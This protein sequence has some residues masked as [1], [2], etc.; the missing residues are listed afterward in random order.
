VS[1]SE[2]TSRRVAVLVVGAGPVGLSAALAVRA[3]GLPVAVL[4][5]E[6]EDQPKPGSR[7]IFVHRESLRHLER[8]SP[9]LGWGLAERGLVWST[10]RTFWGRRQVY[11]HTY[12]PPA[13]DVLPHSTNLPQTDT[14]RLLLDACRSAGIEVAWDSRVAAVRSQPDGV[15]V[16]TEA[17]RRWGAD[18]VV[19]ADGAQSTVR[20]LLAIP[21]EGSRS[22]NVFVIVDVAEDEEAPR[23]PERIFHY[24]HPEVGRRNVLLVPFAGGWRADL[25]CRA[26]DD[27]ERWSDPAGV[28]RWIGAVLSPGYAERV[29]WVS[30]YRFLQVVAERFADDTGR[31]LLTGEAAHLFAPFGAR[32]MNSGIA[33]A[34]A[35]AVAIGKA[36][37]AGDDPRARRAAVEDFAAR[38]R[39]AALY[40]RQA[41][42][43]ALAHLQGGGVATR[44]GGLAAAALA[45]VGQRAGGWLDA[46]PYG[47]RAGARGAPPGTY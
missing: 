18:Y 21:L 34:A 45:W 25:Q 11:E 13:A 35:A 29:T 19:A 31:V 39:Q 36:I 28:R 17:G 9:G 5:A 30:S 6:P 37:D 20:R 44:V 23:R 10:K 24:R 8:V 43:Q 3:G 22:E 47:P 26:D 2:G 41:A 7:A 38:R 4:E 12:P 16:T 42:Q 40:N 32:G 33:D 14:E 15:V 46:A 27:P 1:D